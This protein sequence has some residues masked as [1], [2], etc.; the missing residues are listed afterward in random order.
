MNVD[1]F[2]AVFHY[3]ICSKFHPLVF[4]LMSIDDHCIKLLYVQMHMKIRVGFLELFITS[5]A[6]LLLADRSASSFL[7]FVQ[8]L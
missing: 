6:A 4:T 5:S 8:L 1:L 7:V 2:M 3:F